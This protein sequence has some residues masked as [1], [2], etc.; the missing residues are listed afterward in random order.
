MIFMRISSSKEEK[1]KEGIIHLL[2]EN[3]PRALFTAAIAQSLARDEEY[4][5][6]L[7]LDLER[8]NFV[9]AVR[10]NPKGKTYSRRIRWLLD[11]KVYGAYKSINIKHS[12]TRIV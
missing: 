12:D 7:L 2:F 1:I 6:K 9:V 5:K 10:K 3:S 8:K 11:T 4:V